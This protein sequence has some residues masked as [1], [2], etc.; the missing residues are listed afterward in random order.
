MNWEVRTMRSGTSYF[1]STLY[2]KTVLRFWPLWAA[3][4]LMWLFLLPFNLL[5]NYFAMGRS[6]VIPA[7]RAQALIQNARD[8]PDT[9][10]FGVFV[11]CGYG[12]LCAMAVFGYLYNSRSACMMHALPMRRETLFTTQYLAGLSFALVPNLVVAGL[13]L[14]AE[15]PLIPQDSWG[16]CLGSLGIWLLA[17]SGVNL[18]FF[19]FAAF[20]AMFTGH[21]LA[22]PAF[23]GIFN[24][25]VY[26]LYT[27]IRQLF[28][29]F[30]F[31]FSIRGGWG[32]ELTQIF[33]PIWSLSEAVDWDPVQ[34]TV[35]GMTATTGDWHLLSPGTVA[36]Y[37]VAGVVLA[38]L[39]LLVY[40][41]RQVESAGDV[42]SVRLVRPVFQYG[43]A[44]CSGLCLG[45]FTT[46]FFGWRN[47]LALAVCVV[48]WAVAGYFVARML[49]SKSFRV[50]KY[51]KGA[52]A[53]FAVMALLCAA[54][55]ADVMGITTW[56]PQTSEVASVTVE[57]RINYP[58]DDGNSTLVNVTDPQKIEKVVALHQAIVENRD[59]VDSSSSSFRPGNEYTRLDVT[60]TLTDGSVVERRYMDIPIR[61]EDMG[62]QGTVTWALSQIAQDRDMVE[63]MYDFDKYE[64]CRLV[65]AY[66][67]R[68][69]AQS[70][71][72]EADT[73]EPYY[74]EGA[75]NDQLKE[76]WQ[77]VRADFDAGTIGVRYLFDDE[78]RRE[79]TYVTDLVFV[80]EVPTAANDSFARMESDVGVTTELR[81]TLTPNAENTL[82]WLTQHAGWGTTV[83]PISHE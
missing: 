31:G 55:F 20:C 23:Y 72:S 2:R 27:L 39:A 19:S 41:K 53:S 14:A 37:A 52:A 76:L 16:T 18:F 49:L 63:A 73:A 12:V 80:F 9:L 58:Y 54:C 26:T 33:T 62:T 13:T 66:L 44:F 65:E 60:Y 38:L 4:G 81:I 46:A 61:V 21:I 43:V 5:N 36:G 75:S 45:M 48:V 50:L 7:E 25:L 34:E 1:N 22:L 28:N 10:Q 74:L 59:T 15:L 68:A 82:S 29:D 78:Q 24:L 51:W 35:N 8:L 79:N 11:A 40:R 6:S 64:Q 3:Y 71:L 32:N 69:G 70:G 57:Y 83:F 77:A 17:Q 30:F 42:V 67:D 56:V 47:R